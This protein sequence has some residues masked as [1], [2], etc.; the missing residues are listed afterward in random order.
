MLCAGRTTPRPRRAVHQATRLA[1]QQLH[2]GALLRFTSP[3]KMA[4]SGRSALL[5]STSAGPKSTLESSNPEEEDG[6][7]LWW[8]MCDNCSFNGT[9]GLVGAEG[10]LCWEEDGLTASPA[11]EASTAALLARFSCSLP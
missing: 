2:P 1:T 10:P 4:T 3:A 11:N 9:A 8:A 7:D 6:Q 5:S